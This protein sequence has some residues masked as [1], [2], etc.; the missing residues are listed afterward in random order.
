MGKPDLNDHASQSGSRASV[1]ATF[2]SATVARG[3]LAV[4]EA[5]LATRPALSC[6]VAWESMN[7]S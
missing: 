6:A 5:L 3:D 2:M 7:S 1:Y 4:A